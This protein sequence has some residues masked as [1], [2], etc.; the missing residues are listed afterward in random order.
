MRIGLAGAYR[1]NGLHLDVSRILPLKLKCSSI[2]FWKSVASL[3]ALMHDYF[4][5]LMRALHLSREWN[6]D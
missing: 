4:K 6:G 3:S 2:H 1:D 5:V